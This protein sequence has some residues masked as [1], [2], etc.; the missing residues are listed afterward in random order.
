[1]KE[2]IGR[3]LVTTADADL[4]GLDQPLLLLGRWCEIYSRRKELEKFD[5][6]VARW[7]WDD[8]D[9]LYAD[10]LYLDEL[11]ERI[12]PA[13]AR[14]LN[15]FHGLE[16]DI[17]YWRILVGPWLGYFLHILFDRWETVRYADESHTI[18]GTYRT[19][20]ADEYLIPD[21]MHDFVQLALGDQWNGALF[22]RAVSRLTTIP[23]VESDAQN[24]G[25]GSPDTGSGDK[26]PAAGIKD[27]LIEA[28]A[29]LLQCFVRRSDAFI[30]NTTLPS[31]T[32]LRLQ[33]S[34][35]QVPQRWSLIRTAQMD[36]LERVAPLNLDFTPTNKFEKFASEEIAA[37]IPK[38]YLEGFPRLMQALENTPWPKQPRFIFISC[39]LHDTVALAYMA[40]KS[41]SG[42]PLI[43][44]QHGGVYGIAKFS[45]AEDYEKSIASRYLTWGWQDGSEKTIPAG[46]FRI[47]EK[48]KDAGQGDDILLVTLNTPRYNYRLSSETLS[49]FN[50]YFENSFRF[51]ADLGSVLQHK[52][53]VRLSTHDYG[54]ELAARWK[55]RFAD[56][57]LDDGSSRMYALMKRARVVVYTYNSTG[58]LECLAAGIPT[59]IFL[60]EDESPVRE[61]VRPFIE[62]LKRVGIFH[63]SPDSAARFLNERWD[64]LQD[65]WESPDV[66]N[67]VASFKDRFCRQPDDLLRVINDEI[68]AAL[69]E[70]G[71]LTPDVPVE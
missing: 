19:D 7:H 70:H 9:K 40:E 24:T 35:W 63:P 59:L 55:D 54:W 33:L 61:S 22:A 8:H 2:T 16:R 45:W 32:E 68:R 6:R 50:S 36:D 44:G 60:D 37:Q 57:R 13:L 3:F 69:S 65:W 1:V 4:E 42:S 5:H 71:T 20:T 51:A 56:I 48:W 10:Y 26:R 49:F 11:Y 64:T 34:W 47:Q 28:V 67:V 38:A 18:T 53:L 39:A 62:T 52:L 21:D 27:R 23:F 25:T 46:I 14:A 41:L 43:Y 15:V 30:Y 31:T 29:T 12:L 58:Y 66:S 17:M